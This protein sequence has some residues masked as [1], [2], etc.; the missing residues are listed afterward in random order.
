MCL[1]RLRLHG[2]AAA[3]GTFAGPVWRYRPPG[4]LRPASATGR[5]PGTDEALLMLRAAS[6]EAA[7]QLN[8]L[9]ARVQELGR[10]DE[11][12]ILEAQALIAGDPVLVEDAERRVRNGDDAAT[13]ARAAAE[14]AAAVLAALDDALIAARASDVRDVGARISRIL[15]AD[16]PELPTLPFI[17]VARDLP[18]SVIVEVPA[19]LLGGIALAGGSLTGHEAILAR[20]LSIPAVVGITGLLDAVDAAADPAGFI[21]LRASLDGGSGEIVLGDES[22]DAPG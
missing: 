11:A 4:E 3:P 18:P 9:A 5:G 17:A 19:G 1:A 7:R 8:A 21:P 2:I 22:P 15:A 14:A 16:V 10:P 6:G 20:A 12:A 13:A